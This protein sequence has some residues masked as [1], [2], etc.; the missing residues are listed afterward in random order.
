MGKSFAENPQRLKEGGLTAS[1]FDQ[2]LKWLDEDKDS[3]GQRYLEM[4][5]RLVGYF[6]R[7]GCSNADELAD[8]TLNRVARRLAEEGRIETE[9]PAKYCYITARFVFMEHLREAQK[10][11]TL[12]D[13]LHRQTQTTRLDESDQFETKER[14]LECLDRCIG[15]LDTSNREI[16][17]RYYLGRER[18]KI[19]N[20]RSL[21]ESLGITMN[22]LAIRACRIRSRIHACVLKCVQEK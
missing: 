7:K 19:E 11:N 12:L 17:L 13:G 5:R 22:A 21:A 6:D 14:M 2:L 20:R 3:E 18:V 16:I 9:T 8:E 4:R 10:H 1:T 15:E